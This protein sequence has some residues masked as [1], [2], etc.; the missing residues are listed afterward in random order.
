M[1]FGATDYTISKHPAIL[2]TTIRYK[3]PYG[4]KQITSFY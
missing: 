3:N 2:P 4:R 1:Y